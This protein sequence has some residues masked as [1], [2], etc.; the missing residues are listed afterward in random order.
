MALRSGIVSIAT[1][2]AAG[3]AAAAGAAWVVFGGVYEVAADRPHFQWVYTA[4]E[5]TLHH[6]VRRRAPPAAGSAQLARGG[7]CYRLHC[8]D[9]HGA[10]GVAPAAA[11]LGMQP[12]PGPLVDAHRVWR[13]Q[14]VAWIT[15]HGVRMSGMP[16]WGGRLADA[17]IEAVAAFVGRELP[18]W[19]PGVPLPAG[20]CALQPAARRPDAVQAMHVHGCHGC[21][22]IPGLVGSERH[23]GPPLEAW[24]R[25][26]LI[27][28]RWPNTP[29]VL[30]A[31]IRDPQAFAP[32]SAMPS[33]GVGEAEA[34][35]IAEHLL[36]LK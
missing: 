24:G 20:D 22:V 3:V 19:T 34:L 12:L 23:V 4:M 11:G 25:R 36:R 31:W 16:A 2:A 29:Q 10:P 8:Q 33:T 1:L 14:E 7:A 32:G 13:P 6:A 30:A 18:R 26:T 9:C 35:A 28:G 21:H 17:D 5:L 27:K 15:R